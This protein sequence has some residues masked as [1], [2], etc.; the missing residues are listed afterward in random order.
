DI[1]DSFIRPIV[2]V[3][4]DDAG[5]VDIEA[6]V[7][8]VEAEQRQQR[9]KVHVFIDDNVLPGRAVAVLH[10]PRELLVAADELEELL[11]QRGVLLHAENKREVWPRAMHV[12]HYLGLLITLDVVE[13]DRRAR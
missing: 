8:A 10:F 13:V 5:F 12:Q 9:E 7:T 1:V 3:A 6:A 2:R 4:A 11:V